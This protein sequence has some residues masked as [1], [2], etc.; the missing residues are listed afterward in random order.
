MLLKQSPRC[1]AISVLL[2]RSTTLAC[3]WDTGVTS[4][5]SKELGGSYSAPH[6]V[7]GWL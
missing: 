1:S 4:P 5:A 7:E 3:P 2:S 6:G